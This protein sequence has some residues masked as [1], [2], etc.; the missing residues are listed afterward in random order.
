MDSLS[1]IVDALNH[2]N[3]FYLKDYG[4]YGFGNICINNYSVF[5]SSD[6]YLKGIDI[7]KIYR[8]QYEYFVATYHGQVDGAMTDIGFKLVNPTVTIDMF[9]NHDIVLMGDIHANQNLYIE[10]WIND[11]ELNNYL[12]TGDWEEIK[13]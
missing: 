7:P 10:K 8:N 6:K 4:L 5:D 9:D 3:L 12:N 11:S 1:P 2:P 13:S